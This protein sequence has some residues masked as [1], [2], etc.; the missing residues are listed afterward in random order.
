M[1]RII[2]QDFELLID[3]AGNGGSYVARVLGTGGGDAR[4]N[5]SLTDLISTDA[6]A[7]ATADADEPISR[8]VT[9]V[10]VPQPEKVFAVRRTPPGFDDAKSFGSRLFDNIFKD[11]LRL[12]LERSLDQAR[13][14]KSRLRLRFNLTSVPELATLP[15]EFLHN[16]QLNH[17]YAQFI[18]TPVVRY[19]EIPEPIEELV[20]T[21]PLRMLVLVSSPS[22]YMRLNVEREWT[23]LQAA[24]KPLQ[25]QNL[26]TLERL[27]HPTKLGLQERLEQRLEN[28]PYHIFHFIG[29][30]VFDQLSGAGS[31]LFEDEQGAGE[32]VSGEV[33]GMLLRN[34]DALRLAVI[35]ACEGARLSRTDSYAGIAQILLQRARIPAV[36]AMQFEIMDDAAITF[37]RRFYGA[38]SN[39]YPVDAAL[40]EARLAIFIA[41]NKVEWATPVLYMRAGDGRMRLGTTAPATATTTSTAA[42]TDSTP[43]RVPDAPPQ[44]D[45]HPLVEHFRSVIEALLDGQLVPFLGMDINLFGRKSAADWQPGPTLPS[46]AELAAYLAKFFGYPLS[47]A[48]D[49]ACVAQY[50]MIRSRGI[51]PLYDALSGI[52]NDERHEPTDLHQFLA[53]AAA[54]NQSYLRTTDSLRRRFLIVTTNYDNLLERAFKNLVPNYHVISYVARGQDPGKFLHSRYA[55]SRLDGSPVLITS[56]NDYKGLSDEYPAILKLPGTVESIE[57]RFAITEDHYS[58][59][60]T[61]RELSGLLPSVLT[62]KLKRSSHLFLGYSLRDWN[63]RALLYRIWEEQKPTY[64]SWAVLPVPQAVDEKFWQACD[65]EIIREDLK[66]YV[67]DLS[68]RLPQT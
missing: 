7:G 57:Q 42:V 18:E 63:M 67:A 9:L 34:H 3:S 32:L 38:L 27:D 56:A 68:A 26:I 23:N 54:N 49:L 36:I 53:R 5:F 21:E 15:L 51:G 4:I 48:P 14:R 62:G 47:D 17:F 44:P 12:A 39:G 2:Y 61:H 24:L 50:A 10:S 19:L 45:D 6:Q 52:F 8:N 16:T 20:I 64:E 33:L 43:A 11:G 60:L 46:S 65:V 35:N 41:G 31:L 55:D 28:N 25:D 40:S 37:A 58:D 29:H 30:G 22:G 66:D 13:M 59:Y 1:P